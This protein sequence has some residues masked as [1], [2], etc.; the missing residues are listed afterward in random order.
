[1]DQL[2]F[3]PAPTAPVSRS[4]SSRQGAGRSVFLVVGIVSVIYGVQTVQQLA[5]GGVRDIK[6][7]NSS[8]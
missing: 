4:S 6:L 8:P 5:L 3:A 7:F 1:M 2:G